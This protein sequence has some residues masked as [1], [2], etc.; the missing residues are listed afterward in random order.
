MGVR[1]LT[2][3]MNR[4]YSKKWKTIEVRGRL[5]IDAMSICFVIHENNHIDWLHGGQYWELR[6]SYKRFITSLLESGIEPIVIFDGIDYTKKKSGVMMR[7]KKS[8]REA[9]S[10][11]LLV[12]DVAKVSP[13]PSQVVEEPSSSGHNSS[14][15]ETSPLV[16]NVTK[17]GPSHATV[18]PL[19]SGAVFR[20]TLRELGVSFIF[21]DGDAD[22]DIASIAN[23]Y[24]C[25]VI[26]NDSDFFF[27]NIRAGYIPFYNLHWEQQP[28]TAQVYHY[29]YFVYSFYFK[30]PEAP[31]LIPAILG[32][33]Y[34]KMLKSPCLRGDIAVTLLNARDRRG[35]TRSWL[36][37][38][39]ELVMYL[40]KFSSL[41][42]FLNRVSRCCLRNEVSI[43]EKN[44]RIAKEFY[45]VKALS[46]NDIM[47]KSE[48]TTS[49]GTTLPLWMIQQF[50][51]G[52]FS[53]GAMTSLALNGS[54]LPN[55]IDNPKRRSAMFIGLPI[56]HC[57][58]AIMLP[59]LEDPD[60][61][62]T[63]CVDSKDKPALAVGLMLFVS[64]WS[65]PLVFS[66]GLQTN[67]N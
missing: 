25:P 40:S 28:V 65:P 7:R 37:K 9:I 52:Q 45:T 13:S 19:F 10:N 33:D 62:E 1:G 48:I 56:R 50:R 17:P 54:V 60:V 14:D 29:E 3:Y 27:F 5:I 44:F 58:Y 16:S 35:G 2:T 20:E 12:S 66:T 11:S 36:D 42:K 61:C 63:V 8:A 26:S 57:M 23:D 41:D 22:N 39:H 49:N 67:G 24:S 4:F 43:I 34:I 59:F 53:L 64:H 46:I 15:S 21:A 51:K 31:L 47:N 18:I 6:Q 32:N 30:S 38:I 55:I